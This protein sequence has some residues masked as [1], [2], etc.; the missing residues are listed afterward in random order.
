M[1]VRLTSRTAE[2]QQQD[3]AESEQQQVRVFIDQREPEH[4][5]CN[6]AQ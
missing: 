1:T 3:E 4:T 2:A 5:L 6:M